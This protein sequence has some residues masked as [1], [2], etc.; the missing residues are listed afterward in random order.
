MVLPK[1][2]PCFFSA[3]C[4]ALPEILLFLCEHLSE[5]I[6]VRGDRRH[7]CW[8]TINGRDARQTQ[9]F[10]YCSPGQSALA[11]AEHTLSRGKLKRLTV[12]AKGVWGYE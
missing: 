11:D 9:H 4:I 2:V 3:V 1:S 7:R 8:R 10:G 6:S 12:V 5:E